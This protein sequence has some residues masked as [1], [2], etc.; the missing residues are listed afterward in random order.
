MTLL[1][2]KLSHAVS[3]SIRQ[4]LSDGAYE[5]NLAQIKGLDQIKL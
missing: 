1:L 2:D 3:G 5:N 4:A